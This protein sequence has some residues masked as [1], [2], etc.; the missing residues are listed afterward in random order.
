MRNKQ[1]P[2]VVFNQF[3]KKRLSPG[4]QQRLY[5]IMLREKAKIEE[6]RNEWK[7]P[8]EK[9]FETKKDWQYWWDNLASITPEKVQDV[10]YTEIETYHILHKFKEIQTVKSTDSESYEREIEIRGNPQT[11]FDFAIKK[12]IRSLKLDQ[13]LHNII[14]DYVWFGKGFIESI[15]NTGIIVSEKILYEKDGQE[16]ER[17]ISLIFGPNTDNEDLS[18]LYFF[19]VDDLQKKIPGYFKKKIL[20]IKRFSRYCTIIKM[21]KENKTDLQIQSFFSEQDLHF[22]LDQ[23]RKIIKRITAF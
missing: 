14:R 3:V 8:K 9:G 11:V 1:S 22:S 15:E 5:L 16:L 7:I 17:K 20:P 12:F 10:C 23:I 6:L 18:A 4:F 21:H 2:T 19:H 13:E